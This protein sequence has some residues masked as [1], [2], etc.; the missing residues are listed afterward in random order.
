VR[1]EGT[2]ELPEGG[3]RECEEDKREKAAERDL[4]S[5]VDKGIC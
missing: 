5:K 2:L 3:S 4:H 1:G